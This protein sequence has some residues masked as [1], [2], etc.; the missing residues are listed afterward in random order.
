MSAVCVTAEID[1][2]WNVQVYDPQLSRIHWK[3]LKTMSDTPYDLRGGKSIIQPS[4]E[5]TTFGL[6]SFRYEGAKLWNNLPSQMKC[7]SS[8]KDFK[9]LVKQWTG[10]SCYC[11]SC[12][13]CDIDQ[14]WAALGH[15]SYLC[16]RNWNMIRIIPLA[17][18]RTAAAPVR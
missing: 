6:K 14:L 1:G 10:P 9:I 4:V 3:P 17:W 11:R 12:V 18:R 2:Y 16:K 15:A 13:L 8:P 5:T 7:A